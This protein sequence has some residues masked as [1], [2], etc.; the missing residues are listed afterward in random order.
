[1]QCMSRMTATERRSQ[2][3]EIATREFSHKGFHGTS[4]ETIAR[5]ADIAQ[6]YIFQLFGSKKALFQEVV[7][8]CF[9]QVTE[10]FA[11]HATG[12]TGSDALRAMGD[13]YQQ[14]LTDQTFLLIQ[15]HG[16]AACD[17]PDI[18]ETVRTGF[19]GLWTTAQDLS[20]LDNGH[21]QRFLAVGML[22]NAAA[23]MDLSNL[24]EPWAVACLAP[25]TID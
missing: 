9:Q 8:R 7:A 16:F 4:A 23:A 13:A 24:D 1:M 14:L 11:E 10:T 2:L 18:R 12:L 5:R 25:P 6:P 22:L 19:K 21:V 15:L 17:D 3:L 20:G